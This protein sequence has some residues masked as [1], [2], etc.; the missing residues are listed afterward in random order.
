MES[1]KP[2]KQRAKLA[3][4]PLHQRKRLVCAHLS[5]ELRESLKKR[6]LPVKKGDTVKIMRGKFRGKTGKVVRV[7]LRK[8]RVYIEKIT[9]KKTDGSEILVPFN[10][11]NLKIVSVDRSD[12]KRLKQLAKQKR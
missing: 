9:R 2:G 6:S 8:A 4:M 12:E 10:A 7:D 5:K 3:E 11:S 1:K